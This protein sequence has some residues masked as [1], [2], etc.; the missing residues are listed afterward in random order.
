MPTPPRTDRSAGPRPPPLTWAAVLLVPLWAGVVVAGFVVLGGYEATPGLAGGPALD[1]P[2]TS[3][4]LRALDQPSLLVFAH[5]QCPCTRTTLDELAVIMTR[6]KG[7]VRAYVLFYA[8]S[9]EP[10]AWAHTASWEDAE[11]IPGVEV[12]AD[13]D[14]AESVQFG[15][16]TS[17]HVLLFSSDGRLQFTGGITGA[18][19]H[20]GDN[21]GRAAVIT[22]VTGGVS[23]TRRTPVFGCPIFGAG[24]RP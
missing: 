19:G 17:G 6:C 2:P 8:P 10:P 7:R 11:R 13:P 5:P 4:I 14:G 9:G 22:L 15:A 24:R 12:L 3:R 16:E 18:R 23:E 20:A 1:W 21:P